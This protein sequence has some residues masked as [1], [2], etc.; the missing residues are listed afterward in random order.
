MRFT[1]LFNAVV[2]DHESFSMKNFRQLISN[3]VVF[4]ANYNI[5]V[6]VCQTLFKI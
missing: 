5:R 4:Y 1:L 3:T 6:G 2:N